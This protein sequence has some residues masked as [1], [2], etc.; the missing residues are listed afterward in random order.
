VYFTTAGSQCVI[1]GRGFE[2]IL[3]A[4]PVDAEVADDDSLDVDR[5][6]VQIAGIIEAENE[7]VLSCRHHYHESSAFN[8]D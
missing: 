2:I 5:V 3:S 1:N 8:V 4:S 6:L 7:T